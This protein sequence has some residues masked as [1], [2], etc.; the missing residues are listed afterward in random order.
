L[1]PHP[2][3]GPNPKRAILRG[4]CGCLRLTLGYDSGGSVRGSFVLDGR[5]DGSRKR[6]AN[7]FESS[8]NEVDL[9]GISG[10]GGRELCR[11]APGGDHR[12]DP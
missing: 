4:E 1:G 9:A 12:L 6:G 10:A 8:D 3:E 2:G 7:G 11:D 5:K